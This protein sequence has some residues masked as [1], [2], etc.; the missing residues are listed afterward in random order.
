MFASVVLLSA[1]GGGDGGEPAPA[2]PTSAPPPPATGMVPESIG[3]SVAQFVGYLLALVP[4][5][6]ETGEALDVSAVTPPL[7]E[8]AEPAAL[9]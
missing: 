5:A 9:P 3:G 8:T 1:C 4:M 2:P 7:S 6:N